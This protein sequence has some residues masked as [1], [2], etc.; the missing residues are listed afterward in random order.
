[1]Y[2]FVKGNRAIRKRNGAENDAEDVVP[3]AVSEATIE[4][5]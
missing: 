2:H 4:K 3:A 5:R 1:M